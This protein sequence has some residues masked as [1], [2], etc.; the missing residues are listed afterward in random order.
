MR[1]EG[2]SETAPEAVGHAVGG[3][4]GGCQSGWGRLL[5][6]TN[7]FKLALAVRGR[8]LG[9]G[10]EPCRPASPPPF[11][12]VPAVQSGGKEPKT[13]IQ[14]PLQFIPDPYP[15]A[16]AGGSRGGGGMNPDSGRLNGGGK[17]GGVSNSL[18]LWGAFLDFP[19]HSERLE[20]TQ[21]GG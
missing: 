6:V 18:G 4:G 3:G 7:E 8:W 2:A 13:L 20:C 21:V 19:F 12:C 17:E 10:W 9:I 14:R 11:Q 16:W 15:P 1:R 5:S